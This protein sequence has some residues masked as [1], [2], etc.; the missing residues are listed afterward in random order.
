MR[1]GTHIHKG[2]V[3][4]ALGLSPYTQMAIC[5]VDLNIL[6]LVFYYKYYRIQVIWRLPSFS[7][8]KLFWKFF[9]SEEVEVLQNPCF[10]DVCSH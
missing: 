5:H 10:L 8:E 9:S 3:A 1:E 4:D 2:Q 7:W 6:D